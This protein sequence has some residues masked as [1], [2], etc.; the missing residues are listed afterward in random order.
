[1]SATRRAWILTLDFEAFNA[2][3]ARLWHD[4]M[5]R[6]AARGRDDGWKFSFFTSVERNA[7]IVSRKPRAT[8]QNATPVEQ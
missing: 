2:Q 7:L 5:H 1:V 8:A 3:T 4:A 6:W